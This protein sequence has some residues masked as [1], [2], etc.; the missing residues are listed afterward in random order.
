[1]TRHAG[2]TDDAA[3]PLRRHYA[4]GQRRKPSCVIDVAA[5]GAS[6]GFDES[7]TTTTPGAESLAITGTLAGPAMI[8]G[9]RSLA[10]ERI[11]DPEPVCKVRTKAE[12]HLV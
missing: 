10:C 11:T 12:H 8:G 5:T 1:M 6:K 4:R 7:I 9:A 2:L 3:L